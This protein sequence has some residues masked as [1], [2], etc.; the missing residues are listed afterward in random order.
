MPLDENAPLSTDP[1]PEIDRSL[2]EG[3]HT[4][5]V[6]F[7]LDLLPGKWRDWVEATAQCFMPVDYAAQGVFAAMSAVCGAGTMAVVT[8]TWSEPIVL[9]QVLIGGPSSGK[10]P[11]LAAVGRLLEAI[12]PTPGPRGASAPLVLPDGSLE[13]VGTKMS[14]SMACISLWREELADW[15]AVARQRDVRAGW[16]SG[17]NA[18]GVAGKKVPGYSTAMMHRP[19]FALGIVGTLTPDRLADA[20]AGDDG[21]AERFLYAWPDAVTKPILAERAA[22]NESLVA[23]LQRIAQLGGTIGDP[24]IQTF[25]RDAGACLQRLLPELRER[26]NE[27]TGIEAAW[28]GKGAGTIVRLAAMLALMEWVQD[29]DNPLDGD[30]APKHVEAAYALWSG[31]FHPHARRVFQRLGGAD[32]DDRA[33][34]RVVRWLRRT[35]YNEVSREHIR[36]DALA[37]SVNA[38]GTDEIVSR[39]VS[40]GV[41]RPMPQPT[42]GSRGR[43]RLRWM[44]NPALQ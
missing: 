1:W 3:G 19:H 37:R 17:W 26:M 5:P 41:L 43:P 2:I 24:A 28:I 11:A 13:Q 20:F 38:E 29:P 9:W 31:Y 25:D 21:F 42:A 32:E 27:A 7:P 39:L 22:D 23:M 33:T 15:L 18:G 6:P 36:C 30:A 12:E 44:V 8:P 35:R 4:A 16:L 14:Q 40:A 10:S 34:R